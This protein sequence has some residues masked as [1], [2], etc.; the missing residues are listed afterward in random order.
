MARNESRRK[1]AQRAELDRQAIRKNAC[2]KPPPLP[3]GL[4]MFDSGRT[5][6]SQNYKE[7]VRQAVRDRRWP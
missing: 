3:A 1:R 4:G 6:T 5:D 7:L 2:A